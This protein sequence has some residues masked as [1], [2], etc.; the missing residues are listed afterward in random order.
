M[1]GFVREICIYAVPVSCA[2]LQQHMVCRHGGLNMSD[3]LARQC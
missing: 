1:G 3:L 2:L